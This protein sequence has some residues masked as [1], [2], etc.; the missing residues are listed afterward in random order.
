MLF[1]VGLGIYD[2][3]DVSV[4][5]QE[6]IR[7]ADL[8]YAE[9][10]TSCLIGASVKKLEQFYGRK[11]CLLSREEIETRP[12]WIAQAKDKKVALLVGGDP[13]VSTT[14]LDLRLRA[15]KMGI[16]TKVIHSSSIV[17]VISGLTG[18][19]NYRFGR[20]TSVPFPYIARGKRILAE[21]PYQVVVENLDRNLHTLLFLDIQEERYMT[22][23]EGS[24]FLLE[25]E[26]TVVKKRLHH[27]LGV[28]IARAG[29]DDAEVKADWLPNLVN[30][31]FGG[32]LHTLVIPAKLHFMEAEAL[33]ALAKAPQEIKK[34]ES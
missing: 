8:V 33:V 11:I 1:F 7:D 24:Q 34:T 31:D 9:F 23:N 17:S 22:A 5:G 25:M 15:L 3:K 10:Y 19:Q 2:E 29:S 6:A 26:E 14:H 18:L 12:D 4:K 28:G 13:M 20:S 27:S 30:H 21:T 16:D 32:P